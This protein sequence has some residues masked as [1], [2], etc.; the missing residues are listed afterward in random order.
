MHVASAIVLTKVATTVVNTVQDQ[1]NNGSIAWN[2][3]TTETWQ[4]P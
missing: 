4:D 2:K 3:Q 1:A